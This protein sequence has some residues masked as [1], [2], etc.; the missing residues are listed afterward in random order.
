[1]LRR[2]TEHNRSGRSRPTRRV[3]I[4]PFEVQA[5]YLETLDFPCSKKDVL[6]ASR[7]NNAPAHVTERL[8]L[9]PE[10]SY[11]SAAE[12]LEAVAHVAR[13]TP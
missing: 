6:R 13:T 2:R 7:L 3:P 1:M 5:D 9:L 12:L 8:E 4:D 11:G 10:R